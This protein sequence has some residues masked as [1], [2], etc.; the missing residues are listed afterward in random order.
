VADEFLLE[1]SSH[2]DAEIVIVGAGL[3]GSA[4]AAMLGK[5][6]WRVVVVDPRPNCPPVFKAEKI[7]ADQANALQKLGLLEA[8]L[9]RAGEIR[10]VRSYYDGRLFALSAKKQYGIYY[11]ELVDTIRAG[12]PDNVSFKPDRS[13]A[14]H[15]GADSPHVELAGGE[16][17]HCRLIVLAAGL[18]GEL[19]PSLGL[20]R[21]WVQKHQSLAA[22]F[23]LV[24]ADGRRFPFDAVTF[25]PKSK[26]NGLDYLSIFA[27]KRGMRANL[28]LF[29]PKGEA[30]LRKF[31]QNPNQTLNSAMPTLRRVIGD[32]QVAGKIASGRIDLYRTQHTSVPGVVLI[33]DAAQNVCPSTGMGLTKIVTDLDLLAEYAPAWFKTPGMGTEKVAQFAEDPRKLAIDNKA[34]RDA[35][36]RRQ[37]VTNYSLRWSIH[38]ARL[39]MSMRF[40]RRRTDS[41]PVPGTALEPVEEPIPI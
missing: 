21:M 32:Y 26:R 30:W 41:E 24:R 8:V 28:F 36:Y 17:L 3:A 35:S 11:H 2:M 1:I 13:V 33:G 19:L 16:R 4:A 40:G 31:L 38:R 9:P 37:A 34:L 15:P 20:K 10:T 14:I 5:Q 7:E 6:G 12:W 39:A 29:P 22:A 23:H 25:Y 27:T 18:N